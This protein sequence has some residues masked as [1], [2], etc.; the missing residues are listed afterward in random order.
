MRKCPYCDFNSHQADRFE[1]NGKLPE[2]AYLAQLLADLDADLPYVA[3]REIQTAFIGGGTPSLMSENF[4][5]R[6]MDAL[7]EKLTWADNA[8]ITMEAN[9]GTF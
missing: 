5:Y 8:E 7:R 4:Y 9:P 3:G 6:L 1:A 2:D